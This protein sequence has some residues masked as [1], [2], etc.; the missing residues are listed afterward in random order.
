M[1]EDIKFNKIDKQLLD[2]E[3]HP[4]GEGGFGAVYKATY[5]L[6]HMLIIVT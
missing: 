4:L 3:K 2:I 1:F 5:L 6:V